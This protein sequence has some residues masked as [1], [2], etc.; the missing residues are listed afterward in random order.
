MNTR[1]KFLKTTAQVSAFTFLYGQLF[2]YKGSRIPTTFKLP[3]DAGYNMEL[4]RGGVGFFTERGGT[5][6]WM[7]SEDGIVVVDTQFPEQSQHLVDELMKLKKGKVDLL[8]N[9]HH[10]G[11]HTAGNKVYAELTDTILAHDNSKSNQMKSAQNRGNEADQ[12]YPTE[13]FSTH[14]QKKIGSETIDLKYFGAAH[15]N[16]DSI[17]HF[18]N[19]NVAHLGDLVF[20]RRFPYIDTGAGAN[21][22]NWV[23]VLDDVL[24]TYDNETIFMWGHARDGF[25]IKGGKE[26]IKAFQNYLEKLLDFGEKS[27]KAGK[28]LEELM[29]NTTVIPGA[30]E[31]QG[32]GIERSLKAVYAEIGKE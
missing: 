25:D 11:D 23:N 8:I 26:D 20:N 24:N 13:T 5:I 17:T 10:H 32:K 6:G 27:I 21:I 3:S 4:L 15:T 14:I 29:E 28:S 1:R 7:A 22:S 16:G 12:L 19:A 2:A 9:T 31:W 30:E 18:Q